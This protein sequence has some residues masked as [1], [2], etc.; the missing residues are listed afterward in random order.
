[1][2]QESKIKSQNGCEMNEKLLKLKEAKKDSDH[3]NSGNP[4]TISLKCKIFS[5]SKHQSHDQ[6]IN[7]SYIYILSPEMI[8][9]LSSSISKLCQ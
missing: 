4:L 7:T 5:N 6:K 8:H 9:L 2:L 1:M 3:A